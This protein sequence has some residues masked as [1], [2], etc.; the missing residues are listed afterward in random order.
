MHQGGRL[1]TWARPPPIRTDLKSVAQARVKQSSLH[2][3]TSRTG[4]LAEKGAENEIR[5]Q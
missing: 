5:L 3:A 2:Q 1:S 4:L